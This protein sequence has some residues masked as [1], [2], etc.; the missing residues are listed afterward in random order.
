MEGQDLED[1]QTFVYLGSK[2]A[3][4]GEAD[5]DVQARLNKALGI[6]NKLGPI[7]RS[8]TIRNEV[9]LRLYSSI[10]VPTA[11]YACETW[12]RTANLERKLNVFHRKC[13]RRILRI[14]WRDHVTNAELLRRARQKNLQTIV[15]ER[16]LKMAGH[17]MRLPQRRP[18]RTALDWVPPNLRRGRGRPKKTWR[19]TLI[20]DLGT[21]N[22]TLVEEIRTAQNRNNWRLIVDLCS[23]R[24]GRH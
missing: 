10:V 22:L 3:A 7:W 8:N 4:K 15:N 5:V 2:I 11:I 12:R 19:S 18:A 1:V 23:Q 17:V 24:N 20:E 16:R 9:K 6:F 13:L 14:S 21:A